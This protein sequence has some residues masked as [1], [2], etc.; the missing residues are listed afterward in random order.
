MLLAV[1]GLH[2]AYGGVQALRGIHLV[3]EDG[4]V[5]ALLGANGAGKSSTLRAISG[6]QAPTAGVIS[7]HGESIVGRKPRDIVA[8]GIVQVPEG[9]HLFPRMSVRENLELGAYLRSDGEI[10]ADID[11]VFGHFPALGGRQRQEAGSLSGGEQQMLAIGRALMARPKLLLLD[12]PSL[13][14][15]PVMVEEI[16]NIIAEINRA[17]ISVLLVEQNA[18]MALEVASRGYVLETGQVAASG[19]AAELLAS[20]AIKRAYLGIA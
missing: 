19:S 9:R 2:L 3:L 10:R 18:E 5:I 14:L 6:L 17:G 16:A 20:D 7:F 4:A 8:L 11:R 13:G 12:E 15:S 1:E